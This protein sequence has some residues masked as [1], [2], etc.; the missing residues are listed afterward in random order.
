MKKTEVL[1]HINGNIK[2]EFQINKIKERNGITRMYH[3]NGQL[4]V[5][6]N[7]TNG[8]QDDGTIISYHDN[9][10][11]ARSVFL[12]DG[13]F[14]GDFF[15]W[16]KN[17]EMSKKGLYKNDGIVEEECVYDLDGNLIYEYK[18]KEGEIKQINYYSNGNIRFEVKIRSLKENDFDSQ[19]T[20]EYKSYW[21]NGNL[22]CKSKFNYEASILTNKRNAVEEMFLENGDPI[23]LEDSSNSNYYSSGERKET[24]DIKKTEGD[25]D[26]KIVTGYYKNGATKY[27]KYFKSDSDGYF[28]DE[29]GNWVYY[30][31]EGELLNKKKFPYE[32]D[33]YT[34]VV[35]S[36]NEDLY[37]KIIDN[38]KFNIYLDE[39]SKNDRYTYYKIKIISE[40]NE[41]FEGIDLLSIYREDWHVVGKTQLSKNIA[42]IIKGIALTSSRNGENIFKINDLGKTKKDKLFE[43]T[44]IASSHYVLEHSRISDNFHYENIALNHKPINKE[45]L[46]FSEIKGFL[47][48]LPSISVSTLKK[49]K[50]IDIQNDFLHCFDDISNLKPFLL[51]NDSELKSKQLNQI[52]VLGSTYDEIEVDSVSNKSNVENSDTEE[53]DLEIYLMSQG[54]LFTYLN[55]KEEEMTFEASELIVECPDAED[56]EWE[57]KNTLGELVF[58]EKGDH[59]ETYL[60]TDL[61]EDIVDCEFTNSVGNLHNEPLNSIDEAVEFIKNLKTISF[62]EINP[63]DGESIRYID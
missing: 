31:K 13:N 15:E 57:V 20:H 44:K 28:S 42:K 50:E 59:H 61:P 16:H 32:D 62:K 34:G 26:L 23:L 17:G 14:E 36:R 47:N 55:D 58:T 48:S 1:Y 30:N 7:F 51:D 4:Q 8:I 37:K 39:I 60:I 38:L 18:N 35:K 2:E 19:N 29:F 10:K 52:D 11:K 12:V 9:G 53:D 24:E 25:E 43:M 40:D 63:K 5:E 41:E 22:M 45:P 46:L 3:E 27:I 54:S 49:L 21:I 56:Y 6:I 33:D